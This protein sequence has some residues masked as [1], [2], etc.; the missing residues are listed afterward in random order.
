MVSKACI[1]GAYQRKLE[2]MAEAGPDLELTVAVPPFWRDER[3]VTRL[4]YAHTQGYRL[5]VCRIALNGSFHLHFY[6]WLARL[7]AEVRPDIVHIDE[8]PYNLATYHANIMARRTGARTLWFSWQNLARRYPPPFLWI[9][10]Y[11]LR[12]VDYA[13]VGSRTSAEVWRSKGYSG[14]L[15]VIP[16]FGVDPDVFSPRA[17]QRSG[18]PVHI[19]YVGRFVPEKGVDV[20]LDALVSLQGCWRATLLGSGPAEGQL[21]ERVRALHLADRVAIRPWLPSTTMPDF[22]READV[23]VLP[24]RVQP[25][26]TEQFGRVLI[27]AMACE[28]AVVGSDVGEIPHV[29]GD[30]GRVFPEANAAA[31]GAVLDALMRDPALRRDLGAR[32]RARVLNA[33]TQQQVAR[34]T[35]AVYRAMLDEGRN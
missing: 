15:A 30:A 20:L 12:H 13:I 34:A 35:L 17:T 25:N 10:R 26:W 23:L 19:V 29:I 28:T 9:E 7:I 2:A 31:L 21:R 22:Y 8:E 27:E 3:G 24:S 32:G 16:Q 6:P 11:N 18:G 4:E 1:V 33:Y 14:H 5:T